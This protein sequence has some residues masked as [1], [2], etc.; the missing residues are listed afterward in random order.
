VALSLAG[1]ALGEHGIGCQ[2]QIR[3]GDHPVPILYSSALNKSPRTQGILNP[4]KIMG[5]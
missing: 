1:H 3:K 5:E 4:G 2:I